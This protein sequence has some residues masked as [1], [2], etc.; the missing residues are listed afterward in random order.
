MHTAL[1][2]KVRVASNCCFSCFKSRRTKIK[3]DYMVIWDKLLEEVVKS[4][5]TGE[6][7]DDDE[8]KNRKKEQEV[9]EEENDNNKEHHC[10]SA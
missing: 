1:L 4:N 7:E 8:E 6:E 10:K 9:E 2:W 3:T 5:K